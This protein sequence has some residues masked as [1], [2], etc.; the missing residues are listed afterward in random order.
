MCCGYYI[1]VDAAHIWLYCNIT[2]FI[3][4]CSFTK[5]KTTKISVKKTL[6][7][8]S[9]L[10]S[11]IVDVRYLSNNTETY[12][13]GQNSYYWCLYILR[14]VCVFLAAVVLQR[15]CLFES[16][17]L[18]FYQTNCKKKKYLPPF[19]DSVDCIICMFLT[20]GQRC[21]NRSKIL[22]LVNHQANRLVVC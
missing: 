19:V 4:Y 21:W 8:E 6:N 16:V 5:K 20:N 3:L 12:L 14:Q 11:L 17:K 13:P 22:H 1:Y 2:Y 10:L 9:S 7:L 15:E 18:L